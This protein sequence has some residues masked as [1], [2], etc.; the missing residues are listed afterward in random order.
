MQPRAGKLKKLDDKYVH[1]SLRVIA[2]LRDIHR[3]VR[4]AAQIAAGEVVVSPSHALKELL[5]NSLDAGA[6]G[7]NVTVQDAGLKRLQVQ[8]DGKGISVRHAWKYSLY[9]LQV[10]VTIC[11]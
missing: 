1:V 7:I 3:I 9:A 2:S 4:V 8:D 11:L 10:Y 5:E 6:K